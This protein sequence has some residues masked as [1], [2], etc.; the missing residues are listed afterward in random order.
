MLH[1][2]QVMKAAQ[3]ARKDADGDFADSKDRMGWTARY[4]VGDLHT[5]IEKA[6]GKQAGEDFLKTLGFEYLLED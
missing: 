1:L 2:A 5:E 4:F 6:Y 3:S